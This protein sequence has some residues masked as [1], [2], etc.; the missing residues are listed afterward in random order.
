MLFASMR[1]ALATLI[2]ISF[3]A[4]DMN[5]QQRTRLKTKQDSI[6]Y[7]IGLLNGEQLKQ[8]EADIDVNMMSAGMKDA[9]VKGGKPLLTKEQIQALIQGFQ[10]ELAGKQQAKQAKAGEGNKK[11]GEEFLAANKSKEGVQTTESGLQ[12]KVLSSGKEGATKPLATSTVK[13]HYKGTLLDGSEFD[14]SYKRGQPA[15]FPVNGVIKGW[16][17]G[18]Q[19]MKVGD[20]FQFFIPADL[21]YGLG[22]PPSIGPN[23]MLTFEVELL[24]V[25]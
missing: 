4:C 8:Q 23:Q 12:Y 13:V 16:I 3:C 14:S 6:S 9:M 2:I 10:A 17:E 18:L 19:L 22:A 24:E 21:A 7:A 15:E 5:S 1:F 25:K 20:K 11:R